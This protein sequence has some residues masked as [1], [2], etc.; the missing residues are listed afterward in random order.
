MKQTLQAHKPT[1]TV[2]IPNPVNYRNTNY[3]TKTG[4]Q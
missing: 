4:L 2:K 1:R 3:F